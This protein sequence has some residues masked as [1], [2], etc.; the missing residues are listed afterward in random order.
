M[1]KIIK[2]LF[3]FAYQQSLACI[4]PVVVFVAMAVSLKVQIPYLP[5]YD[6]ILL[7]CIIAQYLMVK[8]GLE[9]KDE[10]NAI[11]VFHLIGLCL[12]IY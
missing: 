5:R 11:T 8:Y 1:I 9:T 12:E 4:F 7:V 3:V 6:F 10:L 2:G